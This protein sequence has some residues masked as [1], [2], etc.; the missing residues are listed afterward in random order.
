MRCRLECRL[1]CRLGCRLE[2]RVEAEEK[3][4]QVHARLAVTAHVV[5]WL[6]LYLQRMVGCVTV[7]L[8]WCA[9]QLAV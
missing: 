7:R 3:C 1:E 9:V 5:S 2:C 8:P 4:K 6:S